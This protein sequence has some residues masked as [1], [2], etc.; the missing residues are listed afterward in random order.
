[1]S[2]FDAEIHVYDNDGAALGS[3]IAKLGKRT[4]G[5]ATDGT[6]IWIVDWHTNGAWVKR[7]SGAAT[8]TSGSHYPSYTFDLVTDS[9]GGITTDGMTIWVTDFGTDRI[10]MYDTMGILQH[11]WPLD[12]ANASPAGITIDPSGESSSVWVLD[13]SMRSVYEY[14]RDTGECLGSFPLSDD[15]RLPYGIADPPPAP[16]HHVIQTFGRN[17]ADCCNNVAPALAPETRPLAQL[18]EIVIQSS[19]IG[20]RPDLDS[21]GRTPTSA[22]MPSTESEPQTT[23]VETDCIQHLRPLVTNRADQLGERLE[24]MERP[25]TGDL[26]ITELIDEELL[27]LLLQDDAL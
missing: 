20:L 15:N 24:A 22:R 13:S 6:D 8:F 16:S 19:M 27:D 18:S 10:Y 21:I 17:A 5:I 26:D 9:P 2:H 7:Y 14:A 12:S 23:A 25:T 1:V 4:E 3:W 11:D